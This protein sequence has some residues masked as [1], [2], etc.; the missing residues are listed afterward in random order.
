MVL[1]IVRFIVCV[2]VECDHVKAKQDDNN[3]ANE[4][5]ALPVVS[6]E[7]IKV[8]LQHFILDMLNVYRSRLD[9]F[10]FEDEINN[11]KAE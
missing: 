10:W 9:H 3:N 2:I 4:L 1:Q 6:H 8:A 11:I 5:D 7:L